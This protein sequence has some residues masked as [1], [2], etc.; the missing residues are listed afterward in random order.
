MDHA[1]LFAPISFISSHFQPFSPPLLLLLEGHCKECARSLKHTHFTT[2]LYLPLCQSVCLTLFIS[3]ILTKSNLW[4][5]FTGL[6]LWMCAYQSRW[7]LYTAYML[8]KY[9][10]PQKYVLYVWIEG[11]SCGY[12]CI[13]SMC[14]C[15]KRLSFPSNLKVPGK[16][17]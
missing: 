16:R 13:Y 5:N 10:W 4:H 9:V 1:V 15:P 6:C 3:F 11:Y 14:A 17:Q 7:T 8:S 12:V 2:W